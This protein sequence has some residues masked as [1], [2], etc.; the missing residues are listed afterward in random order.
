M[1]KRA[2]FLLKSE[3]NAN[4]LIKADFVRNGPVLEGNELEIV[5][6]ISEIC[7]EDFENF[8]DFDNAEATLGTWTDPEIFD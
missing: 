4:C 8:V 5:E 3:T 7:G 2:H 1:E 6:E